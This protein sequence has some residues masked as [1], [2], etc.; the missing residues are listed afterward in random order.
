MKLGAET[1]DREKPEWGE[2]SGDTVGQLSLDIP[3]GAV[4]Q[5]I[6]SYAGHAH[7]LRWFAEPRTYQNSRA[8]VLY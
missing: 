7:H 3:A 6:A 5:R 8:A 2:R 1:I 4:V